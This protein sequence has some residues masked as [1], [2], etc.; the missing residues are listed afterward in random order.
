[1]GT[2]G[3]DA[4]FLAVRWTPTHLSRRELLYLLPD[5][6]LWASFF[7]DR[8]SR[9]QWIMFCAL[10][11]CVWL[12]LQ[13]THQL[14]RIT[15]R[16]RGLAPHNVRLLYGSLAFVPSSRTGSQA[17]L[18]GSYCRVCQFSPA[19]ISHFGFYWG[20]H[21][22]QLLPWSPWN[23]TSGH[24]RQWMSLRLE[25]VILMD[26]PLLQPDYLIDCWWLDPDK[27]GLWNWLPCPRRLQM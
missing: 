11:S 27:W 26:N 13:C 18:H 20:L 24:I 15:D 10:V 3:R 5:P 6:N 4:M 9:S 25:D 8:Q 2:S 21:F 12:S 7:G 16:S 22:P 14:I 1:M 19:S 23:P 17:N